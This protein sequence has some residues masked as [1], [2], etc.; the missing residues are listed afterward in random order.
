MAHLMGWF[1]VI[2]ISWFSQ[3]VECKTLQISHPKVSRHLT[4]EAKRTLQA[5]SAEACAWHAMTMI[6]NAAWSEM[7]FIW[8]IVWVIV[9]DCTINMVREWKNINLLKEAK[10]IKQFL[11][12][13][14]FKKTLM[15]FPLGNQPKKN[16]LGKSRIK[17]Q[18]SFTN[19]IWG[20]LI[21][22]FQRCTQQ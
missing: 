19:E 16:R 7:P 3:W 5:R 21:S 9:V 4:F 11:V 6:R 8:V 13:H 1:T 22:H 17:L 10:K 18:E 14:M 2:W 20:H 12:K 15:H